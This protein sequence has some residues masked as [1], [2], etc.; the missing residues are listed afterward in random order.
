MGAPEPKPQDALKLLPALS[1]YLDAIL[2]K[3][4]LIY[5]FMKDHVKK[6]IPAFQPFPSGP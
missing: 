6:E 2:E 5:W 1:W 3:D 4:E